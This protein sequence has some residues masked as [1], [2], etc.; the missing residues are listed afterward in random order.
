MNPTHCPICHTILKVIDVAPC[1]DC[2]HMPRELDELARGEHT[3]T[4]YRVFGHHHIVL[5]N[6]CEVDFHSYNPDYFGLPARGRL[7]DAN[8]EFLRE[9]PRPWKVAKDKYCHECQRRLAFS[10][11]R[12]AVLES[13]KQT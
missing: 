1:W 12:A 2:G 10:K 8:L 5:C 7:I 4:E 9:F 11:F 13:H 3:Y 6:F